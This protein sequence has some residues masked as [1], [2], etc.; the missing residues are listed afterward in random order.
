RGTLLGDL[1]AYVTLIDSNN[2]DI[3]SAIPLVE[4]VVNNDPDLEIWSAVVELVALT[5]PKQLTPPTAFEKAAFDTPLRSSSASQRG[6]E[7]T[8]RSRPTNP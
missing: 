6:I 4:R 1:S 3:K 5:S 7:Q 8:R 2:F